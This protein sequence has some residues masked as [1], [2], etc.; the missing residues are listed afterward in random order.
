M[1]FAN[2]VGARKYNSAVFLLLW[3]VIQWI[4]IDFLF[5][6][7]TCLSLSVDKIWQAMTFLWNIQKIKQSWFIYGL[8]IHVII[9][10]LKI[11]SR[12][13]GRSDF[14]D[15]TREGWTGRF[16]RASYKALLHYFSPLCIFKSIITFWFDF[17]WGWFDF[18]PFCVSKYL[19]TVATLVAFIWQVDYPSII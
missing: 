5:P 1:I 16:I 9:R 8:Q 3:W 14:T 18:S 4:F 15:L 11:Y 19:L 13:I 7:W 17:V 10:E 12:S 6:W 2:T